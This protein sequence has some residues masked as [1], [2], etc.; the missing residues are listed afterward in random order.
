M[1]PLIVESKQ[2]DFELVSKFTYTYKDGLCIEV[3]IGFVSNFAS[4]PQCLQGIIQPFGDHEKAAVVHDYLYSTECTIFMTRKKA[5]VI[6]LHMMKELGV[7]YVKRTFM[8]RA[9]RLFGKSFW[10]HNKPGCMGS[11]CCIK[12]TTDVL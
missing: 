3:P 1:D 4:V 2:G 7:S 9:V 5:D 10:R 12:N 8:Y 6:F 11:L